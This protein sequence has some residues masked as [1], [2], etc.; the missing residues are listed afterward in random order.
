MD[1]ATWRALG[2]RLLGEQQFNRLMQRNGRPLCHVRMLGG[3]EVSIGG[4]VVGERDWKKRKSRLLF[5][6]LAS[7]RG[8]E[9][10]RDQILEALWPEM[11]EDRA[12]NNFYVACSAMKGSL[13]G[14]SPEERCPYVDSSRGRCRL[15]ADSVRLD[16]DDFDD[17]LA[18]LGAAEESGDSTGAADALERLSALY[19]GDLLPGDLYEDW[20][21]SIR[22]HYRY[23]FVDAMVRG[24][25]LLMAADDP[26]RALL[27][28]RR[29]LQIDPL[30]EDLYQAALR[31]H[32]L[33]GQ[34]SAAIETFLQ[35]RT[36][37]S[38]ELGLDPSTETMSIYGDILAMEERP[39][40]EDF[41]LATE[42]NSDA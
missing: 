13:I 17:S 30:R 12:R 15:L 40:I 31:A 11:S 4:R 39:R 28:L 33:A 14:P 20:F 42:R 19:R 21:A 29:A 38:E 35:C 24:A 32:L 18:D 6:M 34:R 5:A 36:Y 27:Y 23:S 10:A 22:E 16:I 9:I 7:R 2:V 8:A 41:G 3:L 26:C 1:P 25:R 37:L